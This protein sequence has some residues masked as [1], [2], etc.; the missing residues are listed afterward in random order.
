[1]NE[2]ETKKYQ[3]FTIDFA[4]FDAL[5]IIFFCITILLID[6]HFNNLFFLSLS[7]FAYWLWESALENTCCFKETKHSFFK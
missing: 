2:Q 6:S 4:F 3:N 7:F 5:P 1:M